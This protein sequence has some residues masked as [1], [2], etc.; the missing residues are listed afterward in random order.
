MN[1][2]Y[3]EFIRQNISNKYEDIGKLSNKTYL[4]L[5]INTADLDKYSQFDSG[6]LKVSENLTNLETSLFN[7][8]NA[9]ITNINANNTNN[10]NN[11]NNFNINNNISV[12][13][14]QTLI[15]AK[16]ALSLVSNREKSARTATKSARLKSS[17]SRIKSATTN[18][19]TTSNYNTNNYNMNSISDFRTLQHNR[20]A[21]V[22]N[23]NLNHSITSRDSFIDINDCRSLEKRDR[24][25]KGNYSLCDLYINY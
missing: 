15:R 9:N 10:I 11:T 6:L 4:S 20:N 2:D 1:K 22:E 19:T 7:R 17:H 5:F 23:F 21:S 18:F 8:N 3:E 25:N 16:S 12:S 14:S 24:I 13:Q